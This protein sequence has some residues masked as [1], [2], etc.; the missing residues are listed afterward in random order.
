[1]RSR[2]RALALAL[3]GALGSAV[4]SAAAPASALAQPDAPAA[5]AISAGSGPVSVAVVMPLTVPPTTS[6]LLNADALTTYTQDG[7][8][9]NRQLDAVAGTSAAIGLDPMIVASI[10]VLGSAAPA[11]ALDFLSR[12][13]ALPN[14]MFLLGYADADPALAAVAGTQAELAPLGFDFAI[15]P[16]DFGPAVTPSATPTPDATADSD[17]GAT[18]DATPPP[19]DGTPPP[20]PSTEDLLA[21]PTTLPSIAWP[22]EGT[23]DAAGLAGLATLGYADTLIGAANTTSTGTALVDLG[24]I[25]GLVVDDDITEAVR[26]AVYAPTETDYQAATITLA[27]ALRS[28]SITA[29]G[30]TLIAT[31]DRRW[32]FGTARLASVLA[33]I[34]SQSAS[35]LIPLSAVL[36][37]AKASATLVAPDSDVDAERAATLTALASAARAETSYLQIA[38]DATVITQ[39]RRL[40]VLALSAVGWR[41]DG[42]GWDAATAGVLADSEST[43]D[44]VQ[45]TESSDQ[46]VLSDISSLRL[47][48]SNALPVAVTVYVRV[49]PLRPLLQVENA[50]V[51]VAIEPDSSATASIPVQSITNGDVTVRAE[52]RNASG[53]SLGEPRFLKVILQAGWETA[54][55]LIAGGLVFLIFGGG[56]VRLFL[57]RRRESA[58]REPA[59]Q[60]DD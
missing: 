49:Q 18:T 23:I 55:T 9:L 51:E 11:S 12:L 26:S 5:P 45:V 19:D 8:L 50:S 24:D 43:L 38:E 10:R 17:A 31:L 27:A 30:R 35:Q 34:Q 13:H 37:G 16:A 15:D 53:Q 54:G 36:G 25:D 56:L 60:A 7:G 21:W 39:P 48:I 1:M 33:T 29:P 28:V 52:L 47:H 57:R 46:L 22:S 6:G 4:L 20:L 42:V 59:A 58:A 44:A 14:E 2:S 3:A 40:A 41:D 32:P